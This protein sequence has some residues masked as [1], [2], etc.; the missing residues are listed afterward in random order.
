M[1]APKCPV[2]LDCNSLVNEA[3]N[4]GSEETT[5]VKAELKKAQTENEESLAAIA[6][7]KKQLLEKTNELAKAKAK[8]AKLEAELKQLKVDVNKLIG[9]WEPPPN[10]GEHIIFT[11]DDDKKKE[12]E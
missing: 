4:K 11:L 8:I 6:L 12:A 1:A 2:C 3:K 7:L 10:P 9:M 5:A